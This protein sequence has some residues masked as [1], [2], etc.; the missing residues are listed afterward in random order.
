M[1]LKFVVALCVAGGISLAPSSGCNAGQKPPAHERLGMSTISDRI[2]EHGLG[3]V[4]KELEGM[5]RNSI[6]LIA[7]PSEAISVGA[8]KLGGQPDLPD[9]IEWPTYNDVPLGF[10]GQINLAEATPFDLEE[11]LPK[12]GMLYF[13]YDGQQQTW[14]FDPKDS[15]SSRVLFYDGPASALKRRKA[16]DRL[17]AESDFPSQA[18]AFEAEPRMPAWQSI[19]IDKLQLSEEECNKYLEFLDSIRAASP[20]H[21]LLGHPNQVQGDMM[22][23]CQL[24][25]NGLYCGD[26]SGYRDPRRAVLEKA[27]TDWRLLLQVDSDDHGMMWGDVGHIF[28]WI[29]KQDLAERDFSKCW[30]IL[31]C[32]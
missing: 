20:L 25:S 7:T 32:Y 12:S 22:L 29:R 15:G 5:A 26:P 31:Q 10:I 21:W 3:R 11:E 14:G 4:A 18:V 17:P 28:F 30:L 8:S 9:E 16:S 24:V 2:Q 13:F 19:P 6:R 23:E 27:A 1:H